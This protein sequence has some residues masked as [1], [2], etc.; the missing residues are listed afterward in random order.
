M[1]EK[2][3]LDGKL[4]NPAWLA[5]LPRGSAHGV[6]RAILHRQDYDFLPWGTAGGQDCLPHRGN[7]PPRQT[8]ARHRSA[9][10]KRQTASFFPLILSESEGEGD[11]GGEA[12][13]NGRKSFLSPT[14]T[15]G[16]KA[17]LHLR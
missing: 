15:P 9:P 12:D 11:R 7:D 5:E 16:A 6:L 3:F 4:L 14:A 2:K 17:S 13:V 1:S 10:H 8:A